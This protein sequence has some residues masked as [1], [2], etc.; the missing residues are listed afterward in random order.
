MNENSH[1]H[2]AQRNVSKVH[3]PYFLNKTK[4]QY[5]SNLNLSETLSKRILISRKSSKHLNDLF[6]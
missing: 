2:P 1:S 3:S 6:L 5:K 4:K